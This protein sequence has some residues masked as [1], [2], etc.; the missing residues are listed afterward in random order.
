MKLIL[1]TILLFTFSFSVYSQNII[2]NGDF[3]NHNTLPD[4]NGQIER[5]SPWH[6]LSR[7][8]DYWYNS[9]WTP[10][11]DQS[12]TSKSGQG[13]SGIG[14]SSN[15]YGCEKFGQNILFPLESGHT[16]VIGGYC[17]N[18]NISIWPD[19]C[20]KLSF[21]GFSTDPIIDTLGIRPTDIPNSYLLCETSRIHNQ[22]WELKTCTFT[23]SSN[24]N[25]IAVTLNGNCSQYVLLDSIFC[26]KTDHQTL[27]TTNC[28][29]FIPNAFSPNNDSKNDLF[30]PIINCSH[31]E[32]SIK[33]FN[34]WGEMIF[35]STNI[36]SNWDG[37]YKNAICEMGTYM[38]LI[39]YK[40]KNKDLQR[41]KGDVTLIR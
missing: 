1:S 26:T 41:I 9:V 21:Y 20:S 4:F 5:A 11:F 35:Y 3:E 10:W 27:D 30:K 40:A 38:Y 12:L 28:N 24:L 14:N 13:F 19:T 32:Y 15:G 2:Q 39:E 18:G 6:Q 7:S 17:K 23:S 29:Y 22:E 25:Y 33:I 31:S 34:K 16:Y 37:K 36:N 8:C